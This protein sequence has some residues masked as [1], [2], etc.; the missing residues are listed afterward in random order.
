MTDIED[1]I[2]DQFVSLI[3]ILIDTLDH[4]HASVQPEDSP[5]KGGI[6]LSKTRI[7]VYRHHLANPDN[8]IEDTLNETSNR[9]NT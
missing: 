5:L 7:L 4:L 1:T 9:R 3:D 8:S 6:E 2:R